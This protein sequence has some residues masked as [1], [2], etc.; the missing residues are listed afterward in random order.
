MLVGIH[1]LSLITAS[2][3]PQNFFFFFEIYP[4]I[5]GPRSGPRGVKADDGR[6]TIGVVRFKTLL[7]PPR[8]EGQAGYI[9]PRSRKDSALYA[10]N[11]KCFRVGL[12][13]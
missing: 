1:A 2:L 13:S 5:Q 10:W 3:E 4:V 12:N 6:A 7:T 9:P 8:G 11:K